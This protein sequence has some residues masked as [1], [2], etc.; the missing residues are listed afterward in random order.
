MFCRSILL[1]LSLACLAAGQP[2]TLVLST[3]DKLPHMALQHGFNLEIMLPKAF[4]GFDYAHPGFHEGTGPLQPRVL[5][6]PGGTTANFYD[7]RTDSYTDSS[8]DKGW[9]GQH[10]EWFR[11]S[12]KQLG[13]AAFI[14]YCNANRIQPIWVL[15]VHRETGADMLPW[16]QTIEK[17]GGKVERVELANEPYWDP[18]AHSDVWRYIELSRPLAEELK[19]LR[20]GLKVA[21]CLA[22]HGDQSNYEKTWNEPLMKQA[23]FFDAVVHHQYDGL[24]A[25]LDSAPV[26]EQAEAIIHPEARWSKMWEAMQPTLK[27]RP[28]WLTEWNLGAELAQKRWRD[29]GA[30]LLYITAVVQWLH[31]HS[32]GIPLVCYHQLYQEGFGTFVWDKD[33]KKILLQPQHHLWQLITHW[34]REMTQ[35]VVVKT[36][37][38]T[39]SALLSADGEPALLIS[40]RSQDAVELQVQVDGKIWTP[41]TREAIVLPSLSEALETVS[42]ASQDGPSV[43]A[44]SV[45]VWR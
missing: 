2:V 20:P 19:K 32:A 17:E 36:E 8:M 30:H 39:V 9:A 33:A 31:E 25:G 41:K 40:N 37:R 12:G 24:P 3:K 10:V 14:A 34:R 15:N 35:G 4:Q 28:M 22:P 6:F 5:R 44:R 13:R 18:R 29:T 38:L 1:S 45:N 11:K 26:D 43:A 7:W 42:I 23:W 27:A 21:A 16:L